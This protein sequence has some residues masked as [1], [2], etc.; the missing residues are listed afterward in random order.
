MYETYGG[1]ITFSD[2]GKNPLSERRG[3]LR[4]KFFEHYP[5]LDEIFHTV[6]N[7]IRTLFHDAFCILLI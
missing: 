2:F 5:R 7:N 4:E 6:V 1:Q 3:S